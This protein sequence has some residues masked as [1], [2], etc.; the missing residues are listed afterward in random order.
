MR[1]VPLA[2]ILAFV[3]LLAG[4]GT[5]RLTAD[6][7]A[8]CDA[9]VRENDAD[10]AATYSKPMNAR[11]RQLD[12]ESMLT[13]YRRVQATGNEKRLAEQ[14][15]DELARVPEICARSHGRAACEGAA[16]DIAA[17]KQRSR[18]RHK[19]RTAMK[20]PGT[21]QGVQP[22]IPPTCR[23]ASVPA[24]MLQPFRR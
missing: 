11:Y 8:S 3:L 14:F 4:C 16:A 19:R 5:A 21:F 6:Q 9:L 22:C 1:Y 7:V 15:Y 18:E 10:E 13:V 24:S 23:G 2:K 17:F 12:K 20:C